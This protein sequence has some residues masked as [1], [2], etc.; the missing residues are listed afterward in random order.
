M[1][2]GTNGCVSVLDDALSENTLAAAR[3]QLRTRAWSG[4]RE[5]I[6]LWSWLKKV[7]GVSMKANTKT[8]SRTR[9]WSG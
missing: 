4:N 6:D 1:N 9:A 3:L 5:A 7:G 8:Q 2:K